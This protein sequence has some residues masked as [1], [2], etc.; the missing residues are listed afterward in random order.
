MHKIQ[1]ITL[2]F[3]LLAF[4]VSATAAE[5][6]CKIA[7]RAGHT[8]I[9]SGKDMIITATAKSNYIISSFQKDHK[10]HLYFAGLSCMEKGVKAICNE[11]NTPAGKCTELRAEDKD[12]KI[13]WQVKYQWRNM[14]VIRTIES[15]DYPG[16]KLTYDVEVTR[17]FN[18]GRLCFSFR[19]PQNNLYTRT[20]YVKNGVIQFRPLKKAEWFAILRNPHFP[21]VTFSGD[22]VDEGVM[23]MAGDM[24]SWNLLPKTL[25]YAS[26]AKC[27]WT[28]EW[29]YQLGT[30]L[31]KGDKYSFSAYIMPVKSASVAADAQNNFLLLKDRLK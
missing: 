28:V 16:F 3:L 12:G 20:G 8:A 19:M 13:F 30:Q 4:A 23:I 24:K 21:Y 7:K 6:F 27:Y 29:V 31:K 22:K 15:G 17:D 5:K 10:V 9:Y 11:A 2:V 18:L 14:D 1:K 26:T 25:L